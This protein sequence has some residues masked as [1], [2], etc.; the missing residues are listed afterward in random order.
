VSKRLAR[1]VPDL[2]RQ[3]LC[4]AGVQQQQSCS[5]RAEFFMKRGLNESTAA[6][7]RRWAL[8]ATKIKTKGSKQCRRRWKNFL[9]RSGVP[10]SKLAL[11]K[12]AL[13]I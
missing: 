9:V 1:G 3:S 12:E 13:A 2:S 6:A 7:V 5:A 11:M 10:R 8:I 4:G